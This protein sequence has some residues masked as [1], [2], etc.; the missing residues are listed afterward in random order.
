V[1]SPFFPDK[2]TAG[3]DNPAGGTVA[4]LNGKSVRTLKHL[5]EL[6]R[7]TKDEFMVIEF[8]TNRSARRWCLRASSWWRPPSAFSPTTTFAP[9][10]RRT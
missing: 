4:R 3:Y 10:A 7:D 2:L 8:S 9:R 1:S 6:L 5:V